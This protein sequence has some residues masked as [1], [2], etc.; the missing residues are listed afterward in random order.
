MMEDELPPRPVTRISRE[1][2]IE[3]LDRNEAQHGGVQG[4]RELML[5]ALD[6]GLIEAG[7]DPL[8]GLHWR[9]TRKGLTMRKALQQTI[10]EQAAGS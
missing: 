4:Y 8:G 2:A 9:V 3:L 10:A 7:E 1:R 6:D 5:S